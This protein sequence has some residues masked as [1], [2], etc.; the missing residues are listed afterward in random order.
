MNL[1][2][3]L[4]KIGPYV[5]PYR[6]LVIATL[7]LT[8][9]GSFIAQVNAVVLDRTVDAINALV[10]PEGFAAMHR[11]I[12]VNVCA[13]WLAR[14]FRRL[15]ST[16]SSVTGWPFSH[17]AETKRE[18]CRHAS[19]KVWDR[20]PPPSRVCSSTCCRSSHQP[21]WHLY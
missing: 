17:A 10:K 14:T 2:L 16:T 8:L 3:L 13:S 6:W 19:I 7:T 4:K 15:S 5:R 21:F 12:L 1:I 11:T 20:F 18:S 9:I